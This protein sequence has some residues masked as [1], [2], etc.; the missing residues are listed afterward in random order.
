MAKG[1]MVQY[2]FSVRSYGLWPDVGLLVGRL[3]FGV[4]MAYAHGWVK[5][6]G[7]SEMV[8]KFADPIGL[9]PRPSLILLVFAEFFCAMLVAVGLMTRLAAV[10]LVI[11]MGVA[12]L[13]VHRA[14]PL[15][16]KELALLYLAAWLLILMAGPG[17]FSLDYVIGG[18]RLRSA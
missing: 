10:P 17:R 9:G 12:G 18:R 3:T 1:S 8:E 15:A 16:R 11:A 5:L 4:I 14:D 13:I 7:F 2:L 6:K